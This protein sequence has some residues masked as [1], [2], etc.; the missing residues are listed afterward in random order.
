MRRRAGF[1]PATSRVADE[2]TAIFTT[3]RVDS[4]RGT[5]DAVAALAGEPPFGVRGSN[6]LGAVAPLPRSNRHLHHRL[7]D[8]LTPAIESARWG[9]GDIGVTATQVLLSENLCCGAWQP[10]PGHLHSACVKGGIRT[11]SFPGCE[12]SEI[13]TTSVWLSREMRQTE[14][15]NKFCRGAVNDAPRVRTLEKVRSAIGIRLLA[16][17]PPAGPARLGTRLFGASPGDPGLPFRLSPGNFE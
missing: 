16:S 6:P 17:F 14:L 1:E 2:V 13:F 11:R 12:V 10:L 3:D 15:R 8:V 4:W 7:A 5:G 9:T